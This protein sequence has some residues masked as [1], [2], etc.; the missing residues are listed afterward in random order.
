M[1]YDNT[2]NVVIHVVPIGKSNNSSGFADFVYYINNDGKQIY[3]DTS[4]NSNSISFDVK[5]EEY[6]LKATW[7]KDNNFILSLT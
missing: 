4:D 6:N 3:G 7:D 2:N 1:A 5:G